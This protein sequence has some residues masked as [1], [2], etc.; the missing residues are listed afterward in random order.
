MQRNK[1]G[2]FIGKRKLIET[3]PEEAQT[4]DFID[5]DFSQLP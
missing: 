5:K 3:F 2:A 4:L 1:Y